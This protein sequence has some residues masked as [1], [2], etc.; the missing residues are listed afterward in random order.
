MTTEYKPSWDFYFTE[1]EGSPASMYLDLGL[2]KIAPIPEKDHL[3][4]IILTMNDPQ[5]NGFSSKEES[6]MLFA[7]EDKITEAVTEPFGAIFAGRETC[8]GARIFYYYSAEN[9]EIKKAVKKVMKE[10]SDYEYETYFEADEKWEEY[11]EHLYPA[12]YEM[13]TILN[14]RV[15]EGLRS[16]GDLLSVPREVDHYVY[17]R[18]EETKNSFI[19]EAKK[20]KYKVTSEWTDKEGKEYPLSV[21]LTKNDPVTYNDVLDYTSVLYD[22]AQQFDGNYDGWETKLITN[23]N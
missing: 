2:D 13:H 4:T 19:A 18:T 5:E 8:D 14:R 1:L 20:L 12:G 7:I 16:K 11:F 3:L 6:E 21:R 22:L 10:F 17:F 23:D 9:K 15:V